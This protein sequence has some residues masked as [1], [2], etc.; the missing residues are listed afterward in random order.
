MPFKFE[1]KENFSIVFA[2]IVDFTQL[3]FIEFTHFLESNNI[4]GV[5][6][7]LDISQVGEMDSDIIHKLT[8]FQEG[9]Y[10]LGKSF[11]LC[12]ENENLYQDFQ[13][14]FPTD[15]IVMAP[16]M[17]EAIDLISME[18]LE[19]ELLAGGEDGEES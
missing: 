15:S 19:R 4:L 5:D 1:T 7:I 2:N 14:L 8:A 13:T 18:L 17:A 9:S 6:I 10:Q 12:C 16:T 11:V 3:E